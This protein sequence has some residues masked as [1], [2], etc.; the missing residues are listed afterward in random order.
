MST[1]RVDLAAAGAKYDG[2]KLRWDL[3]PWDA[4]EEVAR[5]YTLGAKKYADRNWEKGILYNRIMA[6]LLRHLL[7]WY[8]G[9]RCDPDNGQPHLASVV[10]NSLALLAYERRGMDG[11][12]FD[13][14]PG[15]TNGQGTM[16]HML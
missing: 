16:P 13:D 6:A 9:E 3:I 7:A 2:E 15:A 12:D 11:G 8:K 1:G 10:W 5:V 14:R 4:M